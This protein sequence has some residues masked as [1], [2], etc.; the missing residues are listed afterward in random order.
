MS[1]WGKPQALMKTYT[2][3][4]VGMEHRAGMMM[5]LPLALDEIQSIDKKINL[6]QLVYE[7]GN[8]YGKVRGKPGGGT[9]A[10]DVWK[11]CILSTGEQP[12]SNHRTMDGV[13]T[14]LLE[15][16][17]EPINDP[18]M[19]KAIHQITGSN[20]GFAGP[21]YIRFLID[22]VLHGS[23]S[24]TGRSSKDIAASDTGSP[25]GDSAATPAT[26]ATPAMS[27]MSATAASA[28]VSSST[29]MT[30]VTSAVTSGLTSGNS[31]LKRPAWM[32]IA[33]ELEQKKTAGRLVRDFKM[34]CSA[35]AIVND[36]TDPQFDNIAVLALADYYS[37]LSV[38]GLSEDT[39]LNEAVAL[40]SALL[41]KQKEIEHIDF[42]DR[43][44]DFV[45]GW[46]A[47]NKHKFESSV[48][49]PTETYGMI[50]GDNYYVIASILNAALEEA[51]FNDTKSTR[52]FADRGYITKTKD[53]NGTQR[54]QLVRRIN[55]VSNRVYKLNININKS[56][57]G[58]NSG[59]NPADNAGS[60]SSDKQDKE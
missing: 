24:G 58:G 49:S 37:S 2:S 8:G 36:D 23:S 4:I 59:D 10:T 44:W 57:D 16:N 42:V 17:A 27:A 7:L 31:F 40:G 13:N 56:S 19:G 47:R 54:T 18:V 3:T 52:G 5:H 20:Y 22:D 34:I 15:V 41:E 14:R 32:L 45:C 55:G 11:N 35:L 21:K 39:A 46:V 9:K 30:A 38:F 48:I 12:I 53:A 50:E 6:G 1:V 25:S 28:T 33:E 29:A 60:N 26:P 51:G 43:A